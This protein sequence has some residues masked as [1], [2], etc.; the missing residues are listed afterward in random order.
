MAGWSSYVL[1]L[2]SSQAA[3]IDGL[4]C[5]LEQVERLLGCW[6]WRRQVEEGY[7]LDRRLVGLQGHEDQGLGETWSGG[8][9][10]AGI[11]SSTADLSPCASSPWPVAVTWVD[12][13]F[14]VTAVAETPRPPYAAPASPGRRPRHVFVK[15]LDL[16]FAADADVAIKE[17]AEALR[18][19]SGRLAVAPLLPM[20]L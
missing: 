18:R 4:H 12:S 16:P 7:T 11:N 17:E 13:C 20:I 8:C 6:A 2:P 19:R 5:V 10:V 14:G 15:V 3:S 1:G 9:R